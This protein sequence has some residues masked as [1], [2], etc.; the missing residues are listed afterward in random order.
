[1]LLGGRDCPVYIPVYNTYS[2]VILI[3]VISTG[4]DLRKVEQQILV[5]KKQQQVG[6]DLASI[7]SR[8]IAFELS[9]S[10]S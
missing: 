2:L 3:C 5:D 4:K 9:D 7:F 6:T 8:R 10:E 1:M